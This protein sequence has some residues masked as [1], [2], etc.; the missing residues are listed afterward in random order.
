MSSTI[1]TPWPSR[2]GAELERLADRRQAVALAGVEG[3]V[4]ARVDEATEGVGEATGRV[5]G[6]RAGD[7]EAD[8]AGVAEAERHLGD[9]ERPVLLAH[10]GHERADDDRVAARRALHP[11]PEPVEP[12]LHHR[13]QAQPA[14]GRELRA[15]SGP[16]RR[17]RRRRRGP[18]RTRGRPGRS[19]RRSASRRPCGR[20]S[21]GRARGSCGRR[22]AG[23]SGPARSRRS[24]AGRDSRSPRPAR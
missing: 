13:V 19:R 8:G 23:T 18:R 3:Q 17:R 6:L 15:R 22:R 1:R 2:S 12:R 14:R 4:E 5:A 11:L 7:V 9:L 16:R 20:T 10:G 24:S 21:R